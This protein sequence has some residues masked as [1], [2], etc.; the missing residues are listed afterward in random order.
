MIWC[1][2]ITTQK[3]IVCYS[4]SWQ[5]VEIAR[6]VLQLWAG[7]HGYVSLNYEGCP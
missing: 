1:S 7:E 3:W 2:E 6:S 5:A 4:L